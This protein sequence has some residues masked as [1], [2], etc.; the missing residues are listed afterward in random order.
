M[1]NPSNLKSDQDR[2]VGPILFVDG[3]CKVCNFT[4]TFANPQYPLEP[5]EDFIWYKPE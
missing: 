1:F 3:H 4:K 2:L 5:G